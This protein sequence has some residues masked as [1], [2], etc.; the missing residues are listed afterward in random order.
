[1]ALISRTSPAEIPDTTGLRRGEDV[2]QPV[3]FQHPQRFAHRDDADPELLGHRPDLD[4]A[5]AAYLAPKDAFPKVLVD[6]VR[7]AAVADHH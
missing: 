4:L 5:A 6:L 7:D 3:G 1:M 2:D